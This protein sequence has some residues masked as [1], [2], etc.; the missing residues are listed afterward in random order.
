MSRRAASSKAPPAAIFFGAPRYG[1]DVVKAA[2]TAYTVRISWK[3]G[4]GETRQTNCA[5][6]HYTRHGARRCAEGWRDQIRRQL[7]Q[8]RA[9]DS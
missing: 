5:H 3:E 2:G 7:E 9:I 4:E 6:T 8:E 1:V